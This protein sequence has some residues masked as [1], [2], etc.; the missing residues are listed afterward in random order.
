MWEKEYAFTSIFYEMKEIKGGKKARKN[1]YH[2]A[3]FLKGK[4]ILFSLPS[5]D[6]LP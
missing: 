6:L 2:L 1:E 5:A 3:H 4:F